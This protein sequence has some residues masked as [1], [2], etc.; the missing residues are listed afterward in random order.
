MP[1]VKKELNSFIARIK[2]GEIKRYDDKATDSNSA[3]KA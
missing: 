2:S 3:E 1:V